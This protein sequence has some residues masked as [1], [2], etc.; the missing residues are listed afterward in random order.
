MDIKVR[1]TKRAWI[2]LNEIYSYHA[3]I[4]E[5][6]ARHLLKRLLNTA[7]TLSIF[8]TAGR[9]ETDLKHPISLSIDRCRQALQINLSNRESRFGSHYS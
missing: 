7:K 2:T 8:S 1:W 9:I 4:S 5:Q 3:A 6:G